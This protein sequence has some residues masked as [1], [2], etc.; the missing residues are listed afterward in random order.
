MKSWF[1]ERDKLEC[2]IASNSET[3]LKCWKVSMIIY[4]PR[5]YVVGG[6][7]RFVIQ[8]EPI[9]CCLSAEYLHQFQLEGN[10]PSDLLWHMGAPLTQETKRF[11]WDLHHSTNSDTAVTWKVHGVCIL[12]VRRSDSCWFSS[13]W[14]KNYFTVLYNNFLHTYLQQEIWNRRPGSCQS[15]SSYYMPLLMHI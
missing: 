12:G 9:T 10:I 13:T 4:C 5:K 3:C 7:Q 15:P 8:P 6:S 1:W 2:D 11:T 14:C